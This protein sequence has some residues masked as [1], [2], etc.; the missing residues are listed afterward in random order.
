M[1]PIQ[2]LK[3]TI[4]KTANGQD[5]YIQIMSGDQFTVYVVLIASEIEVLDSRLQP[6]KKAK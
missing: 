1:S 2:K 6:K 4:T 3:V 5:E